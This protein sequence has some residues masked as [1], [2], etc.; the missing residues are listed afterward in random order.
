[1][2]TLFSG[3]WVIVLFVLCFL[4]AASGFKSGAEEA[5]STPTPTIGTA[6]TADT[7]TRLFGPGPFNLTMPTVGLSDLS[8][9]RATLTVLFKGT[10]AGQPALWSRTYVMLASQKPAA[11]QLT[12]DKVGGDAVQVFMAE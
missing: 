4:L 8:S 3:R 9:Y 7:I 5:T 10:Q 2:T 12:I 11:R 1:M 6:A